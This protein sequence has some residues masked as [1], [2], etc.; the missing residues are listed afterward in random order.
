MMQYLE[1]DFPKQH[2]SYGAPA[3]RV[4]AWLM[5][6]FRRSSTFLYASLCMSAYFNFLKAPPH[7][8]VRRTELFREYDQ[9]RKLAARAHGLLVEATAEACDIGETGGGGERSQAQYDFILG[10]KIISS[11][12]LAILEVSVSSSTCTRTHA[13]SSMRLT[14]DTRQSIGENHDHAR[15]YLDSASLALIQ[16]H[17]HGSFIDSQQTVLPA[18]SAMERKAVEFFT[19]VLIWI[20]ILHCSTRQAMPR[21]VG[22]LYR[23][24]L[25]RHSPFVKSF[26][27]IVGFEGWVLATLMDAIEVS[28]WKREQEERNR[29]SMREL[30]GRTDSI[31][32]ALNQQVQQSH[33][34]QTQIFAHAVAVHAHT[35]SSG[36]QP[37]V[38][39]IQQTLE[40]AIPL[41]QKLSP[42]CNNLKRLSWAFCVSASLASE[43]QRSVFEKVLSDASSVDS[44]YTTVSFLRTIVEECWRI[45]DAGVPSC[46]WQDVMHKMERNIH[47]IL[48]T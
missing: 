35:I 17:D 13:F 9:F 25:A 10:E 11:V 41:W 39:E 27:E 2:P 31:V 3:V 6:S 44:L 45:L 15:S 8:A 40:R 38:P 14:G 23:Q 20:H 5:C 18:A 24:L 42:D 48:F 21:G 1:E 4:Q 43:A 22:E 34:V 16:Y 28:V 7:D 36:Y 47:G 19:C 33:H 46:N 29:L 12:Q 32:F 26:V 30:I 37:A